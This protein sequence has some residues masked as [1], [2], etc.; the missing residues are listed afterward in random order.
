[1]ELHQLINPMVKHRGK[2][3]RKPKNLLILPPDRS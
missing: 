2:Q 3:M 1:M